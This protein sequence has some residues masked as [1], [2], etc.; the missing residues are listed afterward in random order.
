[1]LSP[2]L[3]LQVAFVVRVLDVDHVHPRLSGEC[4]Q[5]LYLRD[6]GLGGRDDKGA[7]LLHEIVLHVPN[8]ERRAAWIHP[9][10]LLDLVLWNFD[11]FHH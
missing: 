1:V 7:T 5:V 10:F 8:D 6:R 4:E 11:A 3:P 9:D 2:D